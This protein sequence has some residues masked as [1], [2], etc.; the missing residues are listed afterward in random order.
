MNSSTQSANSNIATTVFDVV[1]VGSGIGGLTSAAFSARAGAS[2]LLLESATSVGGRARTRDDN[3]YKFN[4]GAHALYLSGAAKRTLDIL[5]VEPNGAGPSLDGT[6]VLR[7]GAAHAAPAGFGGP[8][9]SSAMSAADQAAFSAAMLAVMEGF[10]GQQGET[11]GAAIARVS[12]N[13]IAQAMLNTLI[14]LTTFTNAP[15]HADAAAMFDQLRLSTGGVSYLHDGWGGMCEQLAECARRAG[16]HIETGVNVS[17]VEALESGWRVHCSSGARYTAGAVV[18]AVD[19]KEAYR[20]FPASNVLKSTAASAIP[21][22]AACFD[23]GLSQLPI[24]T[25]G[26]VLGLDAPVYFSV[27]TRAASLAPAGAALVHLTRY[28]RPEE[29]PTNTVKGELESL[30]SLLQPGWREHL[31]AD[32]WLP[33]AAV[34]QDLPQAARGGLAGRCPVNVGERLFVAGDWVG[35]EGLLSDAAFASGAVAGQSAAREAQALA[36]AAT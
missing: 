24:A 25:H 16:A 2:S 4:L 34:T 6:L 21:I 20:L 8:E 7:N 36:V 3:G 32:Q 1:I 15:D 10:T 18:L 19:P 11:I 13:P 12:P 31:T 33:F 28:L 9:I 27:H 23:V 22:H 30:L 17:H 29:R 5:R 35:A 14:R 26:F